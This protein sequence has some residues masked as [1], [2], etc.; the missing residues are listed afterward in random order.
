MYLFLLK[1]F[2]HG[3][4]PLLAFWQIV[5]HAMVHFQVHFEAVALI[6][7]FPTQVACVEALPGVETQVFSQIPV[8]SECFPTAWVWAGEGSVSCVDSEMIKKV[9][10]FLKYLAATIKSASHE[11]SSS[12]CVTVLLIED[13]EMIR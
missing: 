3:F 5:S 10:S 9:A 12:F 11:F 8:L 4:L 6:E 13:F 2:L 1:G 7:A